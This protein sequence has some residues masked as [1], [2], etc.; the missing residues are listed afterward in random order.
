M[1]KD[2]KIVSKSLPHQN[3]GTIPHVN[4]RK[5]TREN[6]EVSTF[7]NDDTKPNQLL[8]FSNPPIIEKGIL[9]QSEHKEESQQGQITISVSSK[10]IG[11]V[12]R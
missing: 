11:T 1:A 4:E 12:Y 5:T 9:I 2:N 8:A 10:T 3:V 6:D 7:I